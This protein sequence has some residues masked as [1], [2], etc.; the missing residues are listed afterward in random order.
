[1]QAT[2]ILQCSL[3][4]RLMLVQNLDVPIRTSDLVHIL[5]F[6]ALICKDFKFVDSVTSDKSG[7]YL[8]IQFMRALCSHLFCR[9]LSRMSYDIAK[10]L[11]YVFWKIWVTLWISCLEDVRFTQVF[12]RRAKNK[13]TA[14]TRYL[15]VIG[16]VGCFDAP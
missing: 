2:V 16:N 11:F 1:M 9:L 12:L 7:K 8:D 15:S 10:I 4:I 3:H 6:S 5:Y 13:V 14:Y